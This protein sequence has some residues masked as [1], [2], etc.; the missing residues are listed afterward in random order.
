MRRDEACCRLH[1]ELLDLPRDSCLD[2]PI[3]DR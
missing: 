2:G 1:F 3:R